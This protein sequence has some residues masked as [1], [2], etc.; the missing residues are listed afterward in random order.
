MNI[1]F[2][3]GGN[4]ASAMM[5]GL[6]G[7]NFDAG[8]LRA[9]EI[10][11]ELRA[12]LK[13]RFGVEAYASAESLPE[14]GDVVVLAV[15][16]QQIRAAVGPLIPKLGNQIVLSIAAGIRIADLSRWLGG[17]ERIIRCMPNTPALVGAGITAA[18]APP[19][20]PRD[21]RLAVGQVLQAIGKVVWIDNET[22]LDA[23]TAVSGSGP[24]Y[25]FYFMEALR[26]AAVELGLSTEVA[27][28]LAVET[29]VGA[30]KLATQG[31]EDVATLRERVTSRG[32]TTEAALKSMSSDHVKAAIM[33]AVQIASERAREL[34]AELGKD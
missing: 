5:G 31:R 10:V 21:G 33:R 24:A 1:T 2:I 34:G 16:P 29:F 11:P 14:A 4:M 28:T 20:I 19:A 7:Q 6:I 18:Y 25:V 8:H 23:V 3:G 27:N 26:D 12:E 30:A 22:L 9:V 17:Y 15:K 32:G 13:R